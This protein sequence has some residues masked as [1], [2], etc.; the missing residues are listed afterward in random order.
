M[1]ASVC[2][3]LF[4]HKKIVR[5]DSQYTTTVRHKSGGP[6]GKVASSNNRRIPEQLGGIIVS[7]TEL[8][9]LYY[10]KRVE[11]RAVSVGC[12]RRDED[13]LHGLCFG[14]NSIGRRFTNSFR[15]VVYEQ[16]AWK[17]HS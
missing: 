7:D 15:H 16:E 5:N 3:Q 11:Q 8:V 12:Q 9:A 17:P 10:I 14:W 6:G 13:V 1:F 2:L 4:R